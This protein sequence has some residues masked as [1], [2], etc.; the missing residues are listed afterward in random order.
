MDKLHRKNNGF[1]L[2][3]MLVASFVGSLLILVLVSAYT[4]GISLMKRATSMLSAQQK[5]IV[6]M[7]RVE[8]YVHASKDMD[9]YN[10]TPLSSWVTA[11]SNGNFLV[12]YD[13]NGDTSS[14]FWIDNNMYC[15]PDFT[16]DSFTTNA[17][18]NVLVVSGISNE[19]YFRKYYG[20]LIFKLAVANSCNT[21]AIAFSSLTCFVPRN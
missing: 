5:A 6:A 9:L 3:E 19:S 7:N 13:Y 8:D 2:T 21:N 11:A 10:Y 14:F 16:Q 1:T 18:D 12:I 4:N 20:N 15:K 17:E